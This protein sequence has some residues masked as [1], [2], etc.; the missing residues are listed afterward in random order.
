MH[1][2]T[3]SQHTIVEVC[4]LLQNSIYFSVAVMV[5]GCGHCHLPKKQKYN[6]QP[7]KVLAGKKSYFN[8]ERFCMSFVIAN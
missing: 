3:L 1:T 7:E 2:H 4:V 8:P 6:C 5:M